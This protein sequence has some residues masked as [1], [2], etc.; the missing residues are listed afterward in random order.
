[1]FKSNRSRRRINAV[2][3]TVCPGSPSEPGQFSPVGG[4]LRASIAG[5]AQ[6][7]FDKTKSAALPGDNIYFSAPNLKVSGPDH[8][9]LAQ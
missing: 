8:I 7:D 4:A 5:S 1:V 9:P 6:F 3:K 2:P